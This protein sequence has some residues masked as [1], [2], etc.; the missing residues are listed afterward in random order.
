[1]KQPIKQPGESQIIHGNEGRRK[2]LKL[3][4]AALLATAAFPR[5]AKASIHHLG[6]DIVYIGGIV[7]NPNLSGPSADLILNV[8][9]MLTGDD[10]GV[11][12]LS[13]PIHPN[14]NS[15][16]AINAD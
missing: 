8:Y 5:P 10:T 4:S 2:F 11:G 15:H 14:V 9:L 1:M 7:F 12:T 16:L 13:D 3:T 6:G